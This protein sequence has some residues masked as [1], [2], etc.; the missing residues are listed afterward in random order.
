MQISVT[1]YG[2]GF[3]ASQPAQRPLQGL[4][5]EYAGKFHRIKTGNAMLPCVL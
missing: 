2:F 5:I 1:G 3:V 4:F